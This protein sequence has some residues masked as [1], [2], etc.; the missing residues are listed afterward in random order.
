MQGGREGG[1]ERAR[2]RGRETLLGTMSI[3]GQVSQVAAPRQTSGL[4]PRLELLRQRRMVFDIPPRLI[5][6]HDDRQLKGA[7]RVAIS[8]DR[9]APR[10]VSVDVAYLEQG[11]RARAVC[12]PRAPRAHLAPR[13]LPAPLAAALILVLR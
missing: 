4:E 5:P 12:A 6:V 7:A 13:P 1:R 3:T 9:F 11:A 10:R 2:A 8:V